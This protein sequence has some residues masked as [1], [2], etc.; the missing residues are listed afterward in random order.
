MDNQILNTINQVIT[1]QG[2]VAEW[3][4]NNQS[5]SVLLPPKIASALKVGE[6]V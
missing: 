4:D 5:L 2:G 6:F 1:V 3:T